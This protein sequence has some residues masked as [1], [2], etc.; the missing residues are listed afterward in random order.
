[1]ASRA[2]TI[3][4]VSGLMNLVMLPMWIASGI[5]FSTERFPDAVQ[6]VLAF[7][8]LNPLIHSLRTI[9]LEGTSLWSLGGDVALIAAWGGAC[10]ALGLRWFRWN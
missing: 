7:L 1:V 4:T 5:F 9:M 6:P 10:F 8:P 2:Q 3:E